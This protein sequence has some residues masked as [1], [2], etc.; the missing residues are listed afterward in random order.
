M[1][2]VARVCVSA[3]L[4]ACTA[5]MLLLGWT[6]VQQQPDICMA[7]DV[8]CFI[9]AFIDSNERCLPHTADHHSIIEMGI[10]GNYAKWQKA[11]SCDQ[12]KS[13]VV[14]LKPYC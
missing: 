4:F 2:Y 8:K 5:F 6:I 10:S 1:L 11:N 13:A 3:A 14:F 7:V 12:T 9:G